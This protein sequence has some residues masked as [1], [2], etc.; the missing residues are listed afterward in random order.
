MPLFGHDSRYTQGLLRPPRLQTLAGAE[1][2]RHASWLELFFDL[3]FV[4]AVAQLAH[5]V[6]QDHSLLGFA[7]FAALF[8]PVFI[9]WQGFSFYADRFDTDD[10][11]FRVVIL[12]AMLAIA[13]LAVQIAEVTRGQTVGFALAYVAL[14]VLTIGLNI[15]AFHHVPEA[16]PLIGRYIAAFSFSVVLWTASVFLPTPWRFVLWGLGL[17]VDIGVP[18]YS[19]PRF[20]GQIPIHASHIPERFALFTIIVLGESVVAVALGTAGSDWQPTSAAAAGL[21]FLGVACLWWIYFDVGAGLALR[22][23]PLIALRFIYTHL[24]MLAALTAVASGVSLLIGE[25]GAERLDAGARWALGGGA[26]VYLCCVTVLHSATVQGIFPAIVRARLVAVGLLVALSLAGA[27]LRPVAFV[28]LLLAVLVTLV[29][30][31]TTQNLRFDP[32]PRP[33]QDKAHSDSVRDMDAKQL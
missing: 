6:V 16:R 9:A 5:G 3:V 2:D 25:A 13:A 27:S 20:V 29:V 26:A 11:I 8:V 7:I 30:F 21:G 33:Q 4:V 24:P 28:V 18:A 10:V 17:T 12:V 31:E 32:R 19:G 15:R 22:P 1:D 23:G 14:R